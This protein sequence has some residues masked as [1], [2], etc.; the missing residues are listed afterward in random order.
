MSMCAA[1]TCTMRSHADEKGVLH[2]TQCSHLEDSDEDDDDE[3]E[4]EVVVVVAEVEEEEDLER[5]ADGGEDS[6]LAEMRCFIVH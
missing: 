6:S 1:C 5:P 4:A 2:V 3:E